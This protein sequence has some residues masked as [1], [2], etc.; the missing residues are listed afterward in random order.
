VHA[1]LCAGD[2]PLLTVGMP[3]YSHRLAVTR[4]GAVMWNASCLAT[5]RRRTGADQGG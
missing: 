1:A 2:V 3:S 4:Q 5:W